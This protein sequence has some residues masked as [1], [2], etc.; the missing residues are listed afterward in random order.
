MRIFE[1]PLAPQSG[2]G[3]VIFGVLV[4]LLAT[5][6]LLAWSPANADDSEAKK[7]ESPYFHIAS[8]DASV[9]RLP[10]KSTRVDVRIA[11]VI[12]DVTVTQHYRNEGQR[13]IEARYVFPGSTT[14]AANTRNPEAAA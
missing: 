7:A 6:A 11:G 8:S 5:A 2:L 13:A 12:A 3:R 14:S 4:A 10:L 1:T 9:D